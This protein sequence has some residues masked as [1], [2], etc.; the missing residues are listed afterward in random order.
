MVSGVETSPLCTSERKSG[1]SSP[2]STDAASISSSEPRRSG[3]TQ[4]KKK[5]TAI[6]QKAEK[7]G[8][9]VRHL[10][11]ETSNQLV[12]ST[13]SVLNNSFPK[14]CENKRETARRRCKSV[15]RAVSST[16]WHTHA[17]H[18][19]RKGALK[20]LNRRSD[21]DAR[22]EPRHC[23]SVSHRE[24]IVPSFVTHNKSYAE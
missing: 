3:A 5:P 12:R 18:N 13:Q 7:K 21:G 4:N 1:C 14:M 2:S 9:A 16:A 17:P 15:G 20:M 8:G 6:T 23:T 10:L 11:R 22:A 19:T 24:R